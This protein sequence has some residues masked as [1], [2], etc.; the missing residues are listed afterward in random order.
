VFNSCTDKIKDLVPE[1]YEK[2]AGMTA[3]FLDHESTIPLV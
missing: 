2:L 1:N 3:T